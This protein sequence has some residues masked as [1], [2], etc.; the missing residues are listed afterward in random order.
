MYLRKGN[1]KFTVTQD[2][3]EK[4]LLVEDLVK[5]IDERREGD[6]FGYQ[7][8]ELVGHDIREILPE[9]VSEIL[10]DNIEYSLEGNDFKTVIEKI[11]KF[12][13]LNSQ[14]SEIDM[15]PYIERSIST[16]EKLSFSVLL[17][18]K[19]FL[20][21]KIK[22]I[23]ASISEH[24][25]VF[26]SLTG[27]INSDSY[28]KVLNELMD[29]LYEVKVEAVLC[30]ISVEGFA[31]IEMNDGKDKSNDIIKKVGGVLLSTL[32]TKDVSGYL[33]FGRFAVIMVRTFEDEV[34]YPLRRIESNLRKAGILN[35]KIGYNA[36]YK[37]IDMESDVKDAIDIVSNK[38]IDYTMSPLRK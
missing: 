20:Q 23:L 4:K 31:A 8:E 16:P 22:S 1:L 11:I 13:V 27:L 2:N 28:N 21:D 3:L 24:Q 30:I 36:R 35:S 33:G 26:D 9:E 7:K 32:R 25:Q 5:A 19:I 10:N 17:E 29:F 37:K 12:K 34:V 18:K 15:N 38:P 14:K 6:Y